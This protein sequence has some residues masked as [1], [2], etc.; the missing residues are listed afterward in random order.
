MAD[1]GKGR[2]RGMQ[3][4]KAARAA[5]TQAPATAKPIAMG[6]DVCHTQRELQRGVHGQ[7]RRAE[8][9]LEAAAQ[10]AATRVQSQQRGRDARGVAKQAWW[11]WRKAEQRCDAAVQAEAAAARLETALALFRPD[12]CLSDRQWAQGHSR[13]ALAEL[14]GQAGGKVRRLLS[15]QRPLNQRDWAQ[16]PLAQAVAEP[17]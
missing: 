10:A 8:R 12:G 7:W 11:A 14:D 16:E 2:E 13:A 17:L 1:A 4:A 3:R 15:E 5:E 9:L 6:L